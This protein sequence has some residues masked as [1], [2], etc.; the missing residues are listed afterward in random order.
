MSISKRVDDAWRV[1][2]RRAP[3]ERRRLNV[4]RMMNMNDLQSIEQQNCAGEEL[5]LMVRI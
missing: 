3:Q 5:Q 2:R 1:F 4:S